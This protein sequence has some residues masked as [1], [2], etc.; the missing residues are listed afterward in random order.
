[1][2]T[3]PRSAADSGDRA[4]DSLPIGVRAPATRY[5]PGMPARYSRLGTGRPAIAVAYDRAVDRSAR[6]ATMYSNIVVGTDGSDDRQDGACSHAID[7]AAVSGGTIH[8]VS[9]YRS[10]GGAVKVGTRGRAL[11]RRHPH[12]DR[13]RSSTAPRRSPAARGCTVETHAVETR[14]RRRDRRRSPARSAPTP[15]SSA[16]R[17]CA[18][19]SDSC[20]AASRTRS[21]TTPRARWSSSR[22]RDRAR[23][24][25]SRPQPTHR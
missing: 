4:P 2:A 3:P 22:R 25:R 9:A 14:P 10:S 24:R 21:P 11:V 23:Q 13:H 15:S 16:T 12:E 1:M 18:G 5:E 19:P 6:E 7:L 8:I 17:A 20:S